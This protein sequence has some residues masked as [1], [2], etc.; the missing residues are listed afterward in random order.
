MTKRFSLYFLSALFAINNAYA[1]D[2]DVNGDGEANSADIVAIYNRIIAGET[3]HITQ[4]EADINC[5]KQVNSADVVTLYNNIIY[6]TPLFPQFVSSADFLTDNG[7]TLSLPKNSIKSDKN[8]CFEAKIADFTDK[9]VLTIGHGSAGDYTASWI[10]VTQSTVTTHTYTNGDK[11]S[12]FEHGMQLKENIRITISKKMSGIT[13]L[14]TIESNG[15]KFNSVIDWIGDNG[16][17]GGIYAKVS[18]ASL[19]ECTMRWSCKDLMADVWMFGDSYFSLDSPARWTYYLVREGNPGLLLNAFPG[20]KS[21]EILQDFKTLLSVAKP[22]IA[23]WCL[24]MNDR[25]NSSSSKTASS[26]NRAWLNATQEFIAICEN[27]GITPILSTIPTV[28]GGQQDKDFRYHGAKNNYVK[29]SGNRYIDFSE[30][31]GANDETG[32]WQ[33]QGTEGDFLEGNAKSLVRVH[34]S[35]AGAKALYQQF[36]EDCTDIMLLLSDL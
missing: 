36:T 14:L 13:A 19:T 25:D 22:K 33:G 10:E 7:K 23:I 8:L 9:S 17:T 27:N 4:W 21:A 30:A 29:N 34:P 3:S 31:V 26:P 20:A 18:Q 12:S 5:D 6:G 2:G 15:N 16:T 11:S 35:V 1:V 32:L 28:V 24:G